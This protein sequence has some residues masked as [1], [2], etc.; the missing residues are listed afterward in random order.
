[1]AV[2]PAA[3]QD[4]P[5]LPETSALVVNTDAAAEV[6]VEIAQKAAGAADACADS[7]TPSTCYRDGHDLCI[8]ALTDA[9]RIA[10]AALHAE[11]W[12]QIRAI[13]EFNF[14][15]AKD[16]LRHQLPEGQPKDE[17]DAAAKA[18]F[19]ANSDLVR[20]SRA[21]CEIRFHDASDDA[22]TEQAIWQALH[23]RADQS[24]ALIEGQADIFA[25]VQ[26]VLEKYDVEFSP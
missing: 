22:A 24:L 1:M 16:E 2:M 23:C 7:D 12:D 18:H 9:K 15:F 20:A 21:A 5:T 10:C 17:F 6:P 13:N 8:A 19:R 3:A 4:M 11:L 14:E 26:A 25:P